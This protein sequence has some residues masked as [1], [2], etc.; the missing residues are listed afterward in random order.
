MK[1]YI[2]GAVAISLFAY[3]LAEGREPAKFFRAPTLD[4]SETLVPNFHTH[5]ELNVESRINVTN[6]LAASGANGVAGLQCYR[7]HLLPVTSEDEQGDPKIVRIE[8]L[9]ISNLDKQH[10]YGTFGSVEDLTL[11]TEKLFLPDAQVQTLRTNLLAGQRCEIGGHISALTFPAKL[12]T[13]IGM[14]FRPP[15]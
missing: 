1:T 14:S 13:R 2:V 11:L 10:M 12:L 5:S 3:E 8:L 15:A 4:A 7:L 9:G 6:A